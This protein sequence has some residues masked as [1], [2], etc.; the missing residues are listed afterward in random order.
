MTMVRDEVADLNADFCKAVANRDLDHVVG[1][2][3]ADARLLPPNTP[4]AQGPDAIRA[5]FQGF[6]DAGADSLELESIEVYEDGALVVDVG[7]YVLSIQP[8]GADPIQD[9]GKYIVVFQRQGDGQLKM[10][11]DTFNSDEPPAG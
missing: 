2:Y 6:L 1:F 11:A 9:H 8:P 5:V 4:M 3:T 10:V 7:R